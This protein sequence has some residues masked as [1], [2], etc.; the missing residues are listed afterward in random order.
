MTIN[1]I[2]KLL[3]LTFISVQLSACYTTPKQQNNWP[4]NIPDRAI[5]VDAYN[6]QVAAGRNDT[7]L[8]SHLV[9]VKRF[10][11]GLS[12]YPGWNDMTEMVLEHLSDQP[13]SVRNDAIE[14]LSALGQKIC[15]EW[16][17]SNKV[18]NID[19]A[20]VNTWGIS[21]R[22]AVK[23][24]RIF[25]FITQVE[26]DVDALIA[27]DLEMRSITSDRYFPEEDYNDF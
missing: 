2:S 24:E 13:A 25:P 15:I 9:W 23:Q 4:E 12:I 7:S 17:Q 18:R 19:S 20:N 27:R 11:R 22:K 21:L 1:S 14:R 6:Q 8:K 5:F 26:R 3:L 16:A 10:Y